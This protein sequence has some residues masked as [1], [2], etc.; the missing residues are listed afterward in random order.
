WISVSLSMSPIMDAAGTVIGIASVSR[1]MG[2]RERAEARFRGLLEAARDAIVGVGADGRIAMGNAQAE[3]LFG[4]R[5]DE[6]VGQPVEMLVPY[7]VRNVHPGH[8]DRYFADPEPRPMGAG[9]Q[10][11]AR[12]RYGTEFPAE[13]SLSALETEDGLL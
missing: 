12:R 1:D 13:I 3:R 8:R 6:L 7:G 11:A 2:E 5:R 4:Y 9:M 10:L